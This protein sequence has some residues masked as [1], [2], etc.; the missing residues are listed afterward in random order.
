MSAV[1]AI[2]SSVFGECHIPIS[3]VDTLLQ[4]AVSTLCLFEA[5]K[6]SL[7]LYSTERSMHHLYCTN[8]HTVL[9]LSGLHTVLLLSGL[10]GGR[11][12][13]PELVDHNLNLLLVAA[14]LTMHDQCWYCLATV[15]A[16]IK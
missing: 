14:W 5:S 12:L 7:C 8:V 1:P 10:L 4:E 16:I 11:R 3:Q 2:D 9:L 6:L 13:L 15:D